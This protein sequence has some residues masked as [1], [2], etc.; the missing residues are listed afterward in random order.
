MTSE[1]RKLA[2][3]LEASFN[4]IGES[5][6]SEDFAA[7]LLAYVYVCG[8]ANEDV[9]QNGNLV[10]GIAFA[11]QKFNLF[12]GEI[13]NWNGIV[14]SKQYCKELEDYIA[15]EGKL[16]DSFWIDEILERY[17]LANPLPNKRNKR[18]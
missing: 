17:N 5:L 3:E 6:M 8:G 14:L 1:I 11:Q 9:T 10:A 7:K 12:G 18:K 16:Y 2:I 15:T 13:P 4:S